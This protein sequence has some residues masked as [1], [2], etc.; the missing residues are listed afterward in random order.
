MTSAQ[1]I[2][3]LV[4]CLEGAQAHLLTPNV[5]SLEW[6]LQLD[7]HMS[8][9][10]GTWLLLTPALLRA[11]FAK[12]QAGA[13]AGTAPGSPQ[14]APKPAETTQGSPQAPP[15]VQE[16]PKAPEPAPGKP[17]PKPKPAPKAKPAPEPAGKYTQGGTQGMGFANPAGHACEPACPKCEA[18]MQDERLTKKKASAPDFRCLNAKAN[19]PCKGVFWPKEFQSLWEGANEGTSVPKHYVSES[20]DSLE[21]K[22]SA[23]TW[24]LVVP[25]VKDPE[26][27]S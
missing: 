4:K 12:A 22:L 13:Q 1:I 26:P 18:R 8:D 21:R 27:A 16:P 5:R 14:E 20:V 24:R 15:A 7:R 3:R 11:T 6:W 19:K 23:A 9:I 10:I 25:N 2:E 17:A